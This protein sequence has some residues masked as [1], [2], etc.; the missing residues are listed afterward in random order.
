MTKKKKATTGKLTKKDMEALEARVPTT[1]VYNVKSEVR[2]EMT[3]EEL[4][5]ENLDRTGNMWNPKYKTIPSEKKPSIHGHV[6][7]IELSN[8]KKTYLGKDAQGNPLF[9]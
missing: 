9:H 1:T 6:R 4:K 2:K 3:V 7:D 5:R 8:P